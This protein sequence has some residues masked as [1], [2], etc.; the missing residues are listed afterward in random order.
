VILDEQEHRSGGNRCRCPDNR[1]R[2]VRGEPGWELELLVGFDAFQY[3]LRV[4]G[5]EYEFVGDG[6]GEHALNEYH[7][8]NVLDRFH[9]AIVMP[10]GRRAA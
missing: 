4:S 6:V 2:P 8:V 10:F 3:L 1:R 7:V 5:S 9:P